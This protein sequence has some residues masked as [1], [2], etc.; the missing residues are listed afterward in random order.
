VLVRRFSCGISGH[1]VGVHDVYARIQAHSHISSTVGDGVGSSRSSSSGSTVIDAFNISSVEN[2]HQGPACDLHL[3]HNAFAH[4]AL[5]SW[6]VFL[7]AA[8]SGHRWHR[9]LQSMLIMLL[10]NRRVQHIQVVA[11]GPQAAAACSLSYLTLQELSASFDDVHRPFL[12][13]KQSVAPLYQREIPT[14]ELLHN[15][16]LLPHLQ[17]AAVTYVH[18]PLLSNL[19]LPF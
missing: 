3:D 12:V 4:S 5:H 18:P 17:K 6:A 19:F 10:S 9:V 13:C 16:C 2:A 8:T 7:H 15:N 1:I 14:L 11:V